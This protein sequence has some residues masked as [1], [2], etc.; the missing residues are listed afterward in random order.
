MEMTVLQRVRFKSFPQ[1]LQSGVRVFLITVCMG[2]AMLVCG[3]ASAQVYIGGM[4]AVSDPALRGDDGVAPELEKDSGF[5]IYLGN[6]ISKNFAFEFAVVDFG[7][8]NVGPADGVGN[9]NIVEDTLS[10]SGLEIAYLGKWPIRRRISLFVRAG[11]MVWEGE[12]IVVENVL[13]GGVPQQRTTV[14]TTDGAD[15]FGGLGID[16]QFLK[17]FGTTL[18]Y[19][20]YR[21]GEVENAFYGLSLYYT[22]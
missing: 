1:G 11:L 19:N 3:Q 8:Y 6:E 5:R 12:R 15:F 7:S 17:R 16:Y 22:F 9:I 2:A 10:I 14:F 4:Y 13:V 20:Q 18:E 21:T